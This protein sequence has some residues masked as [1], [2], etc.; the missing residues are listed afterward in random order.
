LFSGGCPLSPGCDDDDDDTGDDD[1][2]DSA[3]DDTGATDDDFFDDDSDD[4]DGGSDAAEACRIFLETCGGGIGEEY[5]EEY[6]DVADAGECW[7]QAIADYFYCLIEHDCADPDGVCSN[8]YL[9]ALEEC[10]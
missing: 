3:D 10:Y 6:D 5:C 2:D 7:D 8:A 1:N 9:A 4:D